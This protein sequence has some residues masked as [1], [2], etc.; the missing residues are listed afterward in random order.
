MCPSLED[1]DLVFQKSSDL[2][3]PAY[4]RPAKRGSG[5]T[6]PARP[7]HTDRMAPPSTDFRADMQ[8]VTPTSNRSIRHEVQQ[9]APLVCVTSSGPIGH[10]SGCTQPAMGESGHI[11]LPTNSH[12]RQSGEVAGLPVSKN[13]PGWPNMPWFWDLVELSSQIPLSLPH[14]PNLLTQPFN[15]IPHRNLSSLNLHAW[16]LEPLQSRS[17]VSLRQ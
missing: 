8:Q 7:S 17:R 13:A 6:I 5:Q 1:L 14:L 12:F 15:Q 9:Q 16:L 4:S 10:C 2:E 3:G 11:C